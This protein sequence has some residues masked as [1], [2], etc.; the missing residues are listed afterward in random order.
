M[1]QVTEKLFLFE[2]N[3]PTRTAP[4]KRRLLIIIRDHRHQTHDCPLTLTGYQVLHQRLAFAVKRKDGKGKLVS[5]C[6]PKVCFVVLLLKIMCVI[7]V[8]EK[9]SGQCFLH[10]NRGSGGRFFS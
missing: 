8:A 2:K 10:P 9:I 4:V 1:C 3:L 6:A 5:S 7:Q